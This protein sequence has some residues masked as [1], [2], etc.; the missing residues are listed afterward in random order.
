MRDFSKF[1][2]LGR[3]FLSA[4]CLVFVLAATTTAYTV[5]MRGGKRVE[6]P[7]QF[8]VTKT[9]LTY[10][11][12]PGFSITLQMAAIDIPATERANNET[13][14]SLLGRTAKRKDSPLTAESS[15]VVSGPKALRSV[16]N[17][18]LDPFARVRQQSER[19]YDERRREL[20]L[21]PLEISRARAAAEAERFWQELKQKRA[22]AEANERA[23]ELQAQIAALT[24]QLN[25][26]QARIADLSSVSSG[27]FTVFGGVPFFSSFGRSKVNPA[28]FGTP[29]GLPIGGAFGT[30]HVPSGLPTHFH[31]GRNVFVAPGAHVG[32]RG[33]FGRGPH[34]RPHF[35]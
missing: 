3:R 32:G 33:G 21:P 8:S 17:R 11:A 19:A 24:A 28:L 6:I 14:G 27:A 12:A 16:T 25:F 1:I 20:G 35:R 26:I 9:T 34:V 22:E 23:Y 15:G 31:G 7:A 13:P 30:F 4:A 18:Q 5:V 29:F 10:E 2:G